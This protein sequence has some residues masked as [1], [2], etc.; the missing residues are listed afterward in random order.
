[1]NS[2]Q[3][4]PA[5]PAERRSDALLVGEGGVPYAPSGARDPFESWAE[6]MEVVEALC[7]R[8]PQRRH[9]MQS[10]LFRL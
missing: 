8:W 3:T 6:L 1:M 9:S 7:E 2:S 10:G 5:R 4:P